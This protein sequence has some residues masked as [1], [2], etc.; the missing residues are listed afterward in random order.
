MGVMPAGWGGGRSTKGWTQLVGLSDA[1]TLLKSLSTKILHLKAEKK[2]LPWPCVNLSVP[3]WSE[4]RQNKQLFHQSFCSQASQF[5][6][7]NQGNT[8]QQYPRCSFCAPSECQVQVGSFC[9]T[10][11]T[12][13]LFEWLLC[14][15]VWRK[16]PETWIWRSFA[17]CRQPVIECRPKAIPFS[18]GGLFL[19][20]I[21][22]KH[23]IP[24][25][26]ASPRAGW[27]VL[28]RTDI[29]QNFSCYFEEP[30]LQGLPRSKEWANMHLLRG[31]RWDP[32]LWVLFSMIFLC[33]YSSCGES[34]GSCASA[35]HNPFK[36]SLLTL[37]TGLGGR[38][39]SY[40]KHA[41]ITAF[42]HWMP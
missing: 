21:P 40:E 18:E 22:P 13:H 8:R 15:L 1:K 3:V 10:W 7:T 20:Q 9:W 19:L 35:K 34:V 27:V 29:L 24:S 36:L 5:S 25:P 42:C 26:W 38:A 14:E 2:I 23:C 31:L 41:G 6:P 4:C 32:H 28:M 11:Y 30:H 16:E 33:I 39:V 12:A 37:G 17:M